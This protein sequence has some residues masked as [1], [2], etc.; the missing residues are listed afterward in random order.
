MYLQRLLIPTVGSAQPIVLH[1]TVTLL[2]TQIFYPLKDENPIACT[3]PTAFVSF[4]SIATLPPPHVPPP[5]SRCNS[6][7]L[8]SP[9]LTLSIG[10]RPFLNMHSAIVQCSQGAT[11]YEIGLPIQPRD[12]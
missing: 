8:V 10:C 4:M 5:P 7:A 9:V 12:G 2:G 6:Q 11:I 3:K 1:R